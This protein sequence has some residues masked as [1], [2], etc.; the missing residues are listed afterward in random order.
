MARTPN[1]DFYVVDGGQRRVLHLD[2]NGLLLGSFTTP[3]PNP[4]DVSYGE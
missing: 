3:G 2:A 4:G 1:G